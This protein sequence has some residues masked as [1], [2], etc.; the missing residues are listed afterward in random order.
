[1]RAGSGARGMLIQSHRVCP[2]EDKGM[3]SHDLA[4]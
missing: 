1:M 3:Q 4:L 2:A